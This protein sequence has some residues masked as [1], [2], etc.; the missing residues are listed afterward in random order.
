MKPANLRLQAVWPYFQAT[1]CLPFLIFSVFSLHAQQMEVSGKVLSAKEQLPL[2]GVNVH[3]AGT[4]QGTATAKDG[5]F[6]IQA[7][8]GQTVML[9]MV[10]YLSKEIK[11]TGAHLGNI[12][13]EEDVQ[14]LNSV[15]VVGYG[16]QKKV[17]LTGSVATVDMSEK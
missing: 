12:Q 14:S 8:A 6:I 9:T 11:V 16:T 10:G 4:Q 2:Q 15:V 7:S 17:N 13:L 5:S 1:I 3:I